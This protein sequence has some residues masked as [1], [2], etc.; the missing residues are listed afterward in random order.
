MITDLSGLGA[1][2][3]W[4]YRRSIGIGGY[5]EPKIGI[6]ISALQ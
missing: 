4:Q 1:S 5:R 6:V 3:W 2:L